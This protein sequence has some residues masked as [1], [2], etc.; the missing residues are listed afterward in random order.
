MSKSLGNVIDP[1]DLIAEYGSEAVRYYLARH[2]SPF[3]DSDLTLESF[4]EFY[5][6]HLANGLGNLVSRVMK[7]SED[8]LEQ[9]VSVDTHGYRFGGYLK[10]KLDEFRL[11]LAMN[12]IWDKIGELDREI[13][14][15]KPWES[16]NK[17]VIINLIIKLYQI[18]CMLKSFM[19]KTA[20]AIIEATRKNKK[21]ENLFSRKD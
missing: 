15:K 12:Y 17:E 11:D 10:E 13:Q 9:P 3:E 14:E 20:E 5:N 21:P 2:V 1:L 16:K 19:P 8:N 6:A 7:M 18:G 4:K